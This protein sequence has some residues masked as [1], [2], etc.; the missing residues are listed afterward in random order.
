MTC[1]E[2]SVTASELLLD[3]KR[4]QECARQGARYS[5]YGIPLKLQSNTY[6]VVNALSLPIS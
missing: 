6:Y 2:G 4:V 5:A 1:D 3:P